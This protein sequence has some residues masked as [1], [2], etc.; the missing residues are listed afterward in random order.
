MKIKE[1]IGAVLALIILAFYAYLV[2]YGIEVIKCTTNCSALDFN[3]A[4]ITTLGLIGGL[5]SAF[6]IAELAITDPLTV[7]QGQLFSLSSVPEPTLTKKI[8]SILYLVVWILTG[9]AAFYYGFLTEQDKVPAI[10]D[11]GR[12]WLGLVLGAVYAYFQ[13][14]PKIIKA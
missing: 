3:S 2:W 5:V 1:V 13:L 6:V 4:M 8:V 7:P 9:L 11:M 10:S 14:K 12:T